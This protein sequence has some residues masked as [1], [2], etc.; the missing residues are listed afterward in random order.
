M[1]IQTKI[2]DIIGDRLR[3]DALQA[4]ENY[5]RTKSVLPLAE[6]SCCLPGGA[7]PVLVNILT[8][9]PRLGAQSGADGNLAIRLC[10]KI[11]PPATICLVPQKLLKCDLAFEIYYAEG[12]SE[13]DPSNV[14]ALAFKFS[15]DD[16]YTHCF[17][18]LTAELSSRSLGVADIIRQWNYVPNI[19]GNPET[20]A[21]DEYPQFNAA[22]RASYGKMKTPPA[23]TGIGAD[24]G[25][26]TL[27]ALAGKIKKYAIENPLQVSAQDYSKLAET[28][29]FS[30][31]MYLDGGTCLIS[32]T[33][34]I[35][36]EESLDGGLAE[37]TAQTVANIQ[38][39]ISRENIKQYVKDLPAGNIEVCTLRVYIKRGENPDLAE[40]IIRR[41]FPQAEIKFLEADVCRPELLVEIE[42][43]GQLR[44]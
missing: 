17:N 10:R 16:K 32:G 15:S 13:E 3:A 20:H 25:E 2:I 12:N 30:R 5:E 21:P 34:A 37:Q 38:K 22:R 40:E 9:R 33:A 36:G 6:L 18:E 41:A 8:S 26:F 24:G 14:S 23:A 1:K 4:W 27:I 35:L 39:L 29:L 7:I 11:F 31:A 19:V 42:G 44:G 28:P 43:V